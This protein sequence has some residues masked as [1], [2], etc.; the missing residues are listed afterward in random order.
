MDREESLLERD[1][2]IAVSTTVEVWQP[3][4][5]RPRETALLLVTWDLG[6]SLNLSEPQSPLP[7]RGIIMASTCQ[8]YEAEVRWLV[9]VRNGDNPSPRWPPVI[10]AP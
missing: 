7:K 2:V 8:F 6:K 9:R 5:G 4:L 10:S 1:S 3:L